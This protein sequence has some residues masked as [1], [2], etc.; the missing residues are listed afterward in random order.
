MATTPVATQTSAQKLEDDPALPLDTQANLVFVLKRL[1]RQLAQVVNPIVAWVATWAGVSVTTTSGGTF[2]TIA[3]TT[4]AAGLVLNKPSGAQ[5]YTNT[6]QG[7]TTG[8]LR[9][10]I[11]PGNGDGETGANAG[12]NYG[13]YRYADDGSYLGP[14]AALL[15]NR[16]TGA[17]DVYGRI[18]CSGDL[19]ST[20][21]LSISG[22]ATIT[23]ALSCAAG[24]GL[25][26][27]GGN[28][29]YLEMGASSTNWSWQWNRSTGNLN[30][31]GGSS[32]GLFTINGNG[33]VSTLGTLTSTSILAT[34]S[35]QASTV[36]YTGPGNGVQFIPGY[37]STGGIYYCM[38]LYGNPSWGTMYHR[39]LHSPGVMAGQEFIVSS[40]YFQMNNSG[41]FVANGVDLG[42]D[43]RT[44]T[45]AQPIKDAASYFAGC[46]AFEY[47]RIGIDELDGAPVHEIGLMAQ[48]IERAM[49]KPAVRQYKATEDDPE[50]MRRIDLGAM[51]AL[52]AQAVGEL[53]ARVNTL[54]T[55]ITALEAA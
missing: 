52:A 32:N 46:Q 13:I 24:M 22:S 53:L 30:W 17:M 8:K 20:G 2:L 29:N 18:G 1:F 9:W 15:I 35:V 50:P 21:S 11:Q 3:P 4:G 19:A 36:L 5:G 44:K 33:N 51:N 6:I 27:D 10:Q 43:A 37:V 34:G 38:G 12:S 7:Q 55:R 26:W 14:N 39:L 40:I 16:A 41:H 47:D 28:A 42:S 54:E 48:D 23:G 31:L 45:N 25:V 49:P